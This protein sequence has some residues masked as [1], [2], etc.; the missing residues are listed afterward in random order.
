MPVVSSSGPGRT[1]TRQGNTL[2][3]FFSPGK[4]PPRGAA[5]SARGTGI[6]Q[7]PTPERQP[8]IELCL[9]EVGVVLS[10][11]VKERIGIHKVAHVV[12][13]LWESGW[14]EYSA[15]NDDAIDGVILMRRGTARPVD[16]GG[17][18]YVQ[19]KCGGNGYRKDQQRYP[20]HIG[21]ALGEKY[22]EAHRPRWSRVPGPAV[23]VFVDDVA[24]RESPPAWWVDLNDTASYSPTNAGMILVPK[25]QQF[26]HHSKGDF[27]RLCGTGA[28]DRQLSE[29]VLSRAECVVPKLGKGESLRN[30]AWEFFK[31]W[32]DDVKERTNPVLGEVLVNRVGWKHMTR[33][34]RLPERIVQSWQLL[35]AAKR[36][37]RQEKRI[38]TFGRATTKTFADG[39]TLI[40]DYLG[41]RANVSFPHRHE[42][43][44]QVVLKRNRLICPRPGF[45]E[46]RQKV[47]FYSVY[48]LRRG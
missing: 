40:E 11:R 41:L 43:V 10:N 7:P 22:I 23:L 8:I 13:N 2:A 26:S 36:M 24:N 29:I 48:E 25:A 14:Q 39:N 42:S 38:Y 34:D 3:G 19:V 9:K 30:D 5:A 33:S 44:V 32:R 37:V 20:D 6:S 31:A 15:S 46:E 1:F 27:H 28:H 35:G 18:V 21:V 16:T 17:V 12:E 45:Q 4:A 47:W